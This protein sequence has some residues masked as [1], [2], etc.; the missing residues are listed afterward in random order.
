MHGL[1]MVWHV[2]GV[3]RKQQLLLSLKR[4]RDTRWRNFI[5]VQMS[6]ILRKHVVC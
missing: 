5:L 4:S 1:G 2:P 6:K 3:T